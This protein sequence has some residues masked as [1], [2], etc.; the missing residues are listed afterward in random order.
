MQW[1]HGIRLRY[2]VNDMMYNMHIYREK[3]DFAN[4]QFSTSIWANNSLLCTATLNK[5]QTDGR[6]P[7]ALVCYC[8]GVTMVKKLSK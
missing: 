4:V 3:N 7:G 8:N 1:I 6:L 2:D 5:N